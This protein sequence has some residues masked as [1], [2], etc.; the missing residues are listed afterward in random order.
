MSGRANTVIRRAA[1]V[2]AVAGS[3]AVGA[4]LAATSAD[5]DT[6]HQNETSVLVNVT[7]AG[8]DSG[9][10]AGATNDGCRSTNGG[11]RSTPD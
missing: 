3:V 7:P 6:L 1:S 2:A 4:A 11:C 9:A 8:T 10:V 5:A